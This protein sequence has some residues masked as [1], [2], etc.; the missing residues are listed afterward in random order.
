[1]KNKISFYAPPFP[2]I[3]SYYDM[4]DVSAEFGFS[5]VEALNIFEFEKPDIEVAK[6]LKAYADSKNIKF[7]CFSVF[8]NLVG[9][10]S[11]KM[12]KK[13]KGY[14]DCAAILGSP[15]LHHTI[16]YEC[17]EPDKV[18]PYKD[19]LFEK[20]VRA[21]QEIY[22][23]AEKIGVKAIYEEQ[24]FIFNGIDGIGK[25]I[26]AVDREIGIVA[27]FGNIAQS[28]DDLLEFIEKYSDRI[29]HA[30]IKDA[31]LTDKPISVH[32][33][34][35]LTGRYMTETNIGE[36]VVKIKEAIDLLVKFGYEGFYGT[37]FAA[38]NDNSPY[39]SKALDF[40]DSC[41]N[42]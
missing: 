18:I 1:M 25:L 21:V 33:L 19:E 3:K 26:D 8:I 10:D 4:I 9:D 14:A 27:D 11:E 29:V 7:C 5:H 34:K 12:I 40:V 24:G 41:F 35:T 42:K 39:I 16:A 30:H 20:G 36:G 37:E 2:R 6:K 32:S 28:G 38:Q 31:F 17:C 22:D 13:L 23:Y 15:Y